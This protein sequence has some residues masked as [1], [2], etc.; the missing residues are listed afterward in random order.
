MPGV[1][2]GRAC[3]GCRRQKKKCDEKQPSCSRC[4]RLHTPCIGSG[5]RR[6][7]FQEGYTVPVPTKKR[8]TKGDSPKTS[9]SSSN[10]SSSS[11]EERSEVWLSIQPSNA[12]TVLGQAFV[13]AIHPSMDIRW[14]LAWVYGG[15]LTDIPAR[16]GTNEALDT[17]TDAVVC[18]H[19][20]F[21]AT[22]KMSVQALGK[23]GRALNTLHSY[24]DDPVKA[25]STDTLC[26]VTL[27]LLCQGF[28]PTKGNMTTGHA[29]GAAQILK[30]RKNFRPRDDFEAK[31]LLTLRGPV[32]FEGL[33]TDRISLRGEEYEALV[34]SDLDADT[35]DGQMMRCLARVPRIRERMA[36]TLPGDT[37]FESLRDEA[38]SLY[39]TYQGILTS[40]Q[41]RTT[42][43][44]TPLATGPLY[45]WYTMMYAQAQRMYGL[46][47]TVAI[48][49]NYLARALDP[50][51]TMLPV[52]AAYF[53]QEI[54]LLSDSQV[55]FRPLGS[56]YMLVCLLT[57]RLGTTDALIQTTI[58]NALDEYQYDFDGGSASETIAAFELKLCRTSIWSEKGGG[59]IVA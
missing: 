32:L 18:M 54:L 15:F 40:L 9:P 26:A 10:R 52:E 45:R 37:E 17:A 43:I 46:A 21:C 22:R 58:E 4:L 41:A 47:L 29:E 1:P 50:Q 25:S 23:Y 16:L 7:K 12:L 13:R 31:L 20:D 51:D 35:P 33:F 30:A 57:A 8:N 36:T 42:A 49:L 44:E 5:Q 34:E 3:E 11:D 53:A 38:R 27:L 56:Y 59:Y 48:I 6:Y 39:D 2:S 55:A 14:N 19:S 28:I 24:L